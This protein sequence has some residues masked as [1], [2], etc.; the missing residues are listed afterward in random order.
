MDAKALAKSKRAHSLHNKKKHQ[1]HHG[2]KVPSVGSDDKKPAKGGTEKSHV[3]K[4]KEKTPQYHGSIALPSNWDRY[5]EDFGLASEGAQAS[6]SQP[7]E[8]VMPR[9]KGSDYAHLISEAKAQSQSHYSSDVLTLF[10]DFV[11]GM[12]SFVD[13]FILG[14]GSVI[15]SRLVNFSCFLMST[16]TI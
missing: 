2:L 16:F 7:T 12:S 14:F 4:I 3:Q 10:D 8:S 6:S 5:D 9:S 1:T 15:I 11:G 13:G